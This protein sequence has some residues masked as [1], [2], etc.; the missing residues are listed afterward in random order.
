M[1]SSC[2]QCN[3]L[4]PPSAKFCDECGQDLRN[5]QETPLINYDQPQSYTPKHLADKILTSRSSIEGERKLI[6]VLFADVVG[7]TSLSEKLDPEEVHQIMDGCYK[8]LMNEIH[9]CE[10]TITQFT[11]DGAMALFGAPVALE[12]H[13]QSSCH[14]AISIQKAVGEY[15]EKV[16]KNFGIDF[17]MRIGINSGLVI[18]VSIGDDLKMEYTALGDTIN[19][20]SRMESMARPGTVLAS[21]HTHRLARAYFE[22]ESL[23][24]V[25]VKGKEEPQEAY[26]LIRASKV[27]TRIEASMAKGLTHFAGRQRE[28]EVI[29][30]SFAKAR[31]GH[32]QLVGIVGEAGVGKSRLMLE[33]RKTI[34]A[35]DYTDLEG[36]CLHY[37]SSIAYLPVLDILKSYFNVLEGDGEKSIKEK[38]REKFVQL[39]DKLLGTLPFFHELLSLTVEDEKYLQFDPQQR[40]ERT[41]EALKDLFVSASQN[42]PLLLVVEDLQWM[43]RTSEEFLDYL[44]GWLANTSILLVLVH[45]PEYTHTWGSQ[46]CYS[47]ISLGQLSSGTS[48]KLV[49][50]ILEQGEVVPELRELIL[51]K[52]GG[53]PL[54]VEE[55]TQSLLENGSIHRKN[56]Q[57]VLSRITSEIE[58]PDTIQ[59]IIAARIDRLED[60]LKRIMQVAS[61]IGT[62]FAYR[63]L[64]T[65]TGMNEDLKSQLHNLQGLEFIYEKQLFPELEYIFKHALTQEVAYNT[66]LH[67][68]RKEIHKKIGRTIEELYAENLEE[69]YELLAYHYVRSEDKDKAV[70]YLD[71]ANQKA[72]SAHA[73][74][75]AMGFFDQAMAILDTLPDTDKNSERRTSLLANQGGMFEQFFR[76]P[77]YH[78]MLTQNEPR[79]TGIA[80]SRIKGLFYSCLG[81]C[82]FSFGSFDKSIQTLNKAVELLESSGNT[83]DA[84]YPYT[85]LLWSY[86]WKGDFDRV[87]ALKDDFL[88]TMEQRFDY[89]LYVRTFTTVS[90][91]CAYLGRWDEAVEEGQKALRIAEEFSDNRQIAFAAMN[92]SFIYAL[93]GDPGMAVEYGELG[94]QK[95]PTLA[96]K[97]WGQGGLAWA[98]CRAGETEK[99]TEYLSGFVQIVQTGGF[100]PA[101]IW[102]RMFLSEGYWLARA[103]DKARQ[104]AE[105]LLELADRCG[106]RVQIGWAHNILGNIALEIDPSLAASHYEKSINIYQEIHAENE[107][108]RAYAGYG[109]VHKQRGDTAKAREYLTKALEIFEKLGTMIEP[110]KV[111]TEL[112]DL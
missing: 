8:I 74:E 30:E 39:D 13:A 52:A 9:K 33:L 49:Q 28:L 69:Y 37:G 3:K 2:P 43:D 6:T 110:D 102:G 27:E 91:T 78:D 5:P 92:M 32:G 62:E 58:V 55:L 59:G 93:K 21:G 20:A 4:L 40:K 17:R 54:F 95:A 108:A 26:E 42:K 73:L 1:E 60:N 19:L 86:L 72:Y 76:M 7:Y 105:E 83:E 34:P 41:F 87:L 77:E 12:D 96:D 112:I 46:S 101:V 48:A 81:H 100:L 31:S 97:T 99:G 106:A 80:D 109:R 16:K 88:R 23:G 85:L 35:D 18:V 71:L 75:T 63:I 70:E 53:N 44:I 36:Q 89:S 61:V 51:G 50:S 82:E 64:Q 65:I 79:A 47:Q 14:A 15:A 90:W 66:L 104:A 29:K 57:Y 10:G 38:V 103:Y 24:K 94:V 107:L 98:W 45:R 67:K 56:D 22:F 11:G 68:R 111:R 25:S 84:A